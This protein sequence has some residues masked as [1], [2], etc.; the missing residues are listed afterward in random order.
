MS[1]KL[2]KKSASLVMIFNRDRNSFFKRHGNGISKR[3]AGI[4]LLPLLDY[5]QRS[6]VAFGIAIIARVRLDYVGD[7]AASRCSTGSTSVKGLKKPKSRATQKSSRACC[8]P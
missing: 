2:P 8:P 7:T 3:S 5:L 1:A 4:D 6:K